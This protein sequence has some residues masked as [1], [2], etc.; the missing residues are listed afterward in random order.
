MNCQMPGQQLLLGIAAEYLG[1][2]PSQVPSIQRFHDK[3]GEG[4]PSNAYAAVPPNEQVC[5]ACPLT[6]T[7]HIVCCD[8]IVLLYC[9]LMPCTSNFASQDMA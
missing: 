9:L 2:D 5:M 4:K 8:Y 3:S 6:F 7:V 1:F